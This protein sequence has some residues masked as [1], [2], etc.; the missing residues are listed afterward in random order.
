MRSVT[1]WP[2]AGHGLLNCTGGSAEL[3]M[4]ELAPGRKPI[5]RGACL[6]ETTAC[7]HFTRGRRESREG[8]GIGFLAD[9]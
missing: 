1:N 9:R 8:R 6:D 4:G 7:G 3:G 5:A 2:L